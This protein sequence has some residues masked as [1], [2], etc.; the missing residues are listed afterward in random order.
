MKTQETV[1]RNQLSTLH[2]ILSAISP[3]R[4]FP[5]PSPRGPQASELDSS[6]NRR[7]SRSP[8]SKIRGSRNSVESASQADYSNH[9]SQ[10]FWVADIQGSHLSPNKATEFYAFIIVISLQF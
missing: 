9:S 10:D 5:I 7:S 2:Q 1:F 8:P 4:T 3:K 6:L